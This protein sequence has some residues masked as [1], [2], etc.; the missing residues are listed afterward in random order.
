M[1]EVLVKIGDHLKKIMGNYW[2]FG[3]ALIMLGGSILFQVKIVIDSNYG[4]MLGFIGILATFIVVGN[5]AQV[6]AIKA[7]SKDEL[8]KLNIMIKGLEGSQKELKNNLTESQG[9]FYYS[10][11]VS[12]ISKD[13]YPTALNAFLDAL[14]FFVK[15]KSNSKS[16][17]L[18][19]CILSIESLCS[20]KKFSKEDYKKIAGNEKIK[21]IKKN[22]QS[23]EA[24]NEIINIESII[25][26]ALSL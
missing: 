21:K 19:S 14:D 22:C 6:M 17:N 10:L 8:I 4:I 9:L 23:I 16:K 1:K 2:L 12:F 3:I 11:G 15:S 20:F 7:E 18:E 13:D 25:N 5:Y 24:Y 26:D